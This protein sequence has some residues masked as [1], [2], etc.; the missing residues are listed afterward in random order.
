MKALFEK[1]DKLNAGLQKKIAAE[2]GG[3]DATLHAKK[4]ISRQEKKRSSPA[5]YATEEDLDQGAVG[6]AP[7]Q[8]KDRK[9]RALTT[10]T[11]PRPLSLDE[12]DL[13]QGPV[14]SA[15]IQ[16]KD[17]KERT[18]TTSTRPRALSLDKGL[19][20]LQRPLSEFDAIELLQETKIARPYNKST[21]T[22]LIQLANK[23]IDAYGTQGHRIENLLEMR[24]KLQ[25]K[26]QLHKNAEALTDLG[27]PEK[28]TRAIEAIKQLKS[29]KEQLNQGLEAVG[30]LKKQTE[31]LHSVAEKILQALA[32]GS[33]ELSKVNELLEALKKQYDDLNATNMSLKDLKKLKAKLQGTQPSINRLT[34]TI[35]ELGK[36]AE[37]LK[38]LNPAKADLDKITTISQDLPE[39]AIE[40]QTPPARIE[41]ED[42]YA[43][44]D[45]LLNDP[46]AFDR[47][48][49]GLRDLLAV[50]YESYA[51]QEEAPKK[52]DDKG[53][54]TT[55]QGQ[56]LE[57]GLFGGQTSAPAAPASKLPQSKDSDAP[58]AIVTQPS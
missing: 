55:A 24:H 16:P 3:L 47:E 6:S 21:Y 19:R 7:T 39:I 25:L 34:K 20:H 18:L 14:G 42:E 31:Q 15:P 57:Q 32:P 2:G 51:P 53:R 11:R 1:L 37:A 26:E 28:L 46:S 27:N 36:I 44:I 56:G 17:R 49:N 30:V 35:V 41:I 38:A 48:G 8:P 22:N 13:D 43:Y 54:A 5:P 40:L 4:P 12:E 9:E 10:S 33:K 50:I 58:A 52:A 45:G 29:E 23:T